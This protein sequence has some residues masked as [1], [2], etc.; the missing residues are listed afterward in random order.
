M[1]NKIDFLVYMETSAKDTTLNVK[2]DH[3]FFK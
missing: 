2:L 3:K 1:K